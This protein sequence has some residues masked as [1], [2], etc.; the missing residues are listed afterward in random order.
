MSNYKGSKVN[1]L[2]LQKRLALVDFIRSQ[3]SKIEDERPTME[4]FSALCGSELGF[5]VNVHNLRGVLEALGKRWPVCKRTFNSENNP[6]KGMKYMVVVK[7]LYAL[8]RKVKKL[9]EELG[10]DPGDEDAGMD[11]EN[12]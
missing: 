6:M 8:E 7:R 1:R 2:S 9:H 12:V 4:A 5:T 3:W 11:P 10:I